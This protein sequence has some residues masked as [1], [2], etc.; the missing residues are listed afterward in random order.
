MKGVGCG[1]M[2]NTGYS[3]PGI[4]MNAETQKNVCVGL[5]N[6]LTQKAIMIKARIKRFFHCFFNNCRTAVTGKGYHEAQDMWKADHN[7]IPTK[8][9]EIVCSCKKIFWWDKEFAKK[10]QYLKEN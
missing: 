5:T 9:V 6:F 10:P 2:K 1:K 3:H 7:L 4:L 8:R